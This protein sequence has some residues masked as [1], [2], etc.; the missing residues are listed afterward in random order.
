[1]GNKFISKVMFVIRELP[2]NT[3]TGIRDSTRY[4]ED[5]WGNYTI[6]RP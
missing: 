1:M 2:V 3:V 4:L 6:R 5:V